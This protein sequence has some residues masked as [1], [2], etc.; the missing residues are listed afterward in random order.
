[1]EY[2]YQKDAEFVDSL[3]RH[4]IDG[5]EIVTKFQIKKNGNYDGGE[6]GGETIAWDQSQSQLPQPEFTYQP[7]ADYMANH[8]Q[9]QIEAPQYYAQQ[10]YT[11]GYQPEVYYDS[12]NQTQIQS[13]NADQYYTYSDA[14]QQ[15]QEVYYY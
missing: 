13:Y 10:T 5:K 9:G 11:N 8:Q 1:V 2:V 12:S 6:F 14:D 3:P 4:V 15:G 7:E